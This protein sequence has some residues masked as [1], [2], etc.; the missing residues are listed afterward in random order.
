MPR[1]PARRIVTEAPATV[2]LP[3][4]RIGYLLRRSSQA[5]TLRVVIDPAK[6]VIVTIPGPNRRG[7][8]RPDTHIVA[9]LA[10]REAWIRR[11]LARQAAER[12]TLA[13]RGGLRE[14]A[15]FR[16][17]GELHRL[18]VEHA[19]GAR[20]STVTRVGGD[21]EDELLVRLAASDRRPVAD[22]LD[23]W[24]RARARDAIQRAIARHVEA[25]GVEPAAISIRDQ[26][27]RWGS[28]SR[29]RRLAF[30]W[31]LVLAPPEALDTVVIHELAHLRVFGH[32]PAF[33]A[34][35]AS[36]RPD[37]RHWRRWLRDHA[38]ELHGALDQD[39]EVDAASA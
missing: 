10:E 3:G 18:R 26:R 31:R 25:L 35:V 4:G 16:Y 32:G 12:A 24:L 1:Q 13:A 38:L 30:S 27:T 8:A 19:R 11:H 5:R 21:V 2:D 39:V 15:T 20:R 36:R 17:R 9:F 14:G 37:H 23:A 22:V 7:W 28:A 29:G 34:L 33:W 6:G